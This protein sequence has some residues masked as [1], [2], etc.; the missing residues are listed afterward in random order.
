MLKQPIRKEYFVLGKKCWVFAL[1]GR[2]LSVCYHTIEMKTKI[3]SNFHEFL[4]LNLCFV[5][6]NPYRTCFT[7]CVQ[8]FHPEYKSN[9]SFPRLNSSKKYRVLCCCVEI[10]FKSKKSTANSYRMRIWL[11]WFKRSL[12]L[13]SFID[14]LPLC[15]PLPQYTPIVFHT[16]SYP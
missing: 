4:W 3:E 1:I 8:R 16:T 7:A 15:F 6:K 12:W 13:R 9:S 2:R 14:D 5:W 10:L 11:L